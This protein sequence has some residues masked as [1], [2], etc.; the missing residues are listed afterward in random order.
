MPN[1]GYSWKRQ[2]WNTYLH[3]NKTV[4]LLSLQKKLKPKQKQQHQKTNKQK[5]PEKQMLAVLGTI[6][7]NKPRP[8]ADE[9]LF[10]SKSDLPGSRKRQINSS[11]YEASSCKC[12]PLKSLTKIHS[13]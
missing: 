5:P 1:S 3:T 12:N 2:S 11:A 8:T 9:L 7:A 4:L 10:C 13:F 6:W